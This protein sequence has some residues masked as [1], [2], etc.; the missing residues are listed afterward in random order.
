MRI[1]EVAARA[2]VTTKALRFC[3]QAGVHPEP[4]RTSSGYR[5]YDNGALARL[6]FVK[7]AQSAGLKLA[8]IVQVV[9][10]RETQG[11]P[12]AHVVVL[13]DRH[14]AELEARIADLRATLTD[15]ERLRTRAAESIP[16]RAPP[17]AHVTS[18]RPRSRLALPMLCDTADQ[19]EVGVG[20]VRRA[21]SCAM[22]VSGPRVLACAQRWPGPARVDDVGRAGPA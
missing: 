12:C 13:L 18:Y 21:G 4:A 20:E 2:G 3:E 7:A 11:A 14:A 15:V 22:P 16:R 1:G 6:R 10:V 19:S 8:E 9:V 17:K 5:D